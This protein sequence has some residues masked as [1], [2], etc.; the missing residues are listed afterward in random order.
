[1]GKIKTELKNLYE[2]LL[3]RKFTDR[4]KV[5]T[6]ALSCVVIVAAFSALLITAGCKNKNEETTAQN[7]VEAG[8]SESASETG[9][10]KEQTMLSGNE[11]GGSSESVSDSKDENVLDETED[12]GEE[13]ID[14]TLFLGDSNTVRMMNYG[15]TSL[16]N[17]LAVVGMGIQSVKTLKCIQF[18]G[19]SSPITMVEAVKLLKPRRIIITFGTN[20]ANGMSVD[21]FIKKY[22]EALDAVK[23]AEPSADILINSIPPIAQKNSYP[24]LSQN[25][26]DKFNN[27]LIKMAAERG[28][29]YID[30]ASVMK[31]AATGYAKEGYTVNDG[32]HISESGFA[33]MFTYIRTHSHVVK[34]TT[35]R[36]ETPL[37]KQVKA[38]YVVDSNG[39]MNNDPEA[40]KEMSEVTAEQQEALKKALEETARQLEE[41]KK[42]QCQHTN[43]RKETVSEATESSTGKI[44]YIC[45]DCGY[46]YEETIPK[47]QSTSSSTSSA[48]S[49]SHSYSSSVYKEATVNEEGVMRYKCSCGDYYDKPIPKIVVQ[50]PST[51]TSSSVTTSTSSSVTTSTTVV[52]TQ[53]STSTTDTPVTPEPTPEPTPEQP[54]EQ[55]QPPSTSTTDIT[56]TPSENTPPEPTQ[57]STSEP[58]PETTEEQTQESG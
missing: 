6:A 11:L 1:M 8:E 44:K 26:I 34:D 17:T 22:E 47:K 14:E 5:A 29:K 21:D 18:E 27:A 25:S 23:Q 46:I 20:N 38:T 52:E 42:A 19:Y 56:E 43:H 32:I 40:Y 48:A 2:D 58:E 31:D 35:P 4:V 12:A 36:P 51:S 57:D 16:K 13:Y 10:I 28:Y 9:D 33:A 3:N 49:H 39:K 45:N 50:T 41:S 7:T 30:S 24:S 37:P 55:P 54:P 53:P 15:I